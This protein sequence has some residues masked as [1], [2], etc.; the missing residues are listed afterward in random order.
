MKAWLIQRGKFNTNDTRTN[1]VEGIDSL[2][3]FDYMGSAEFEFG[4]LPKA[5]NRIIE[6]WNDLK[7]VGTGIRDKGKRE[8]FVICNK[9][10]EKEVL[11]CVKHV[12]QNAYGYKEWCDMGWALGTIK[13]GFGSINIRNDFWWD[14]ENDWMTCV[15]SDRIKQ[16]KF[17]I[18]KV[19]EKRKEKTEVNS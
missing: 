6:N 16:V 17:A 11:E 10:K 2:I 5:L 13:R 3:N 15:S 9:N 8:L 14:I 4:A 12:S 18:E 7:I 1:G 19:I